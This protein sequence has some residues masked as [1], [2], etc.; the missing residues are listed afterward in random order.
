V[1]LG[2]IKNTNT[3][4]TQR[5]LEFTDLFDI[6]PAIDILVYTRAEFERQINSNQIGFWKNVKSTLRKIL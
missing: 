2:L 6:F 4:F 1:V 3:P 5:T